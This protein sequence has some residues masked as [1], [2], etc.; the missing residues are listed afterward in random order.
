MHDFHK[1][2]L[3]GLGLLLFLFGIFSYTQLKTGLFPD[4]TFPKI[5]VIADAG[6]QPVDKMMA[7]VTVPLENI[8]KRTEGLDYIISSTSRGSCEISI[9]L[10]WNT[11]VDKAKSQI[12]SLINKIRGELALNPDISVEKMHPSLLQVIGYSLEGNRSQIE[13]KKIAQFQIKPALASVPGVSDIGIMGGRTKEYQVIL[14]PEKLS[15]LGITPQTIAKIITESNV[16]QSNGYVSDYNRMYLCVTDNSIQ[17]KN[18][19]ENLILENTAKRVVKLSDV[20]DIKINE[21]KEYVKIKANGKD[22]PLIAIFKQ[23]N[24]NL[25]EVNDGV[26]AKLKELE[27]VLPKDVKL[28]P[29]YFQADFVKSSIKSIRDVLWLGLLLAIVVVIIFLHSWQTSL[30]VLLTIPVSIALTLGLLLGVGYTF[31]IMTM[32]A[33]AAAI[34]LM[35]DDAVIVVE[36]IHRSHEEYPTEPMQ[37]I[38]S[39]AIKYL[40]PAM[41]SS[42]L[43]TIVIFIPFSLMTGVAGAYFKVLAYTMII[44]LTASFFTTWLFLPSL[45]LLFPPKKNI[46]KKSVT[47]VSGNWSRFF[48]KYP[49]IS[50][51]FVVLLMCV[52]YIVPQHLATGFLP[53]MDEGAIVLDIKSPPGSTLDETDRMLQ[54]VDK[55]IE[56][57]PEVESFSRR[58]GTEMG[59]FITE[60]NKGDYLIELKN[61]RQKT[62]D[63]VSDAI[64]K[65][66]ESSIPQLTFELGQVMGDQLGDLMSSVQPIEIKIFG[67]NREK[68]DSLSRRIAELVSKVPGTADV[69]DGIIAAG[70]SINVQPDVPKLA[71]FGINPSDF[72]F[73]MQTQLDGNIVTSI[74]E[75][76]QMVNVRLMYPNASQTTVDKLRNGNIFL[77]SG[78]LKP[79]NTVATVKIEKG[80]AEIKRQN[81]KM[82]GIVTARLNDRDLGSTLKDIQKTI[83]KNISLPPGYRKEYGG[84]YAQQKQAFS[85]LLFILLSACL[86]VFIIL[87]AMFR[88]FLISIAI[89]FLA[90]IGAAGC[91]LALYIT[92]TPLNVGSYVGI[93]MIVGI[94]GENAIFTYQQYLL[95]NVDL[96]VKESII[97]AIATRLRPKLMTAT[98]DIVAL[99]PLALGIGTGA[100]MHQ[101]LAIA[102]IGGLVIALPL[103]LIVFPTMIR[104][105]KR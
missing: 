97:Y 41:I 104:I 42:S 75:G 47:D 84:S 85:E 28:K 32:G 17:N 33:I 78:L 14:K 34:G 30:V 72:Q 15:E 55:I 60:P 74:I 53:E 18:G 37:V 68:L 2:P 39:K 91:L 83:D 19:L 38:V 71:Q 63:E 23:P 57:Q 100:Q 31:N 5:K 11:D 1:K 40:F 105:I 90:L 102:V 48:L 26:I 44:T 103:L 49:A 3:L 101:P 73:Q 82:L 58:I 50:I 24:A 79:L 67:D 35:I 66:I 6:Q 16:L 21:A 81:Q 87:L 99:F 13:L 56:K 43:S 88:E 86:L 51:V 8:I 45:F 93:I 20:A 92:N 96:N 76:E 29:Y 65:M 80:V 9:F 4:I 59:F 69:F 95:M 27:K 94:I 89:I 12:E 54:L 36:Q 25:I 98:G 46:K 77:P 7:A 52:I 10:N 61:D 22:V 64:R 62:T 70:P